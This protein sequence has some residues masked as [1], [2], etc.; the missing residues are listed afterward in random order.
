MIKALANNATNGERS[1]LLGLS[2]ANLAQLQGGKPIAFNLRELGLDDCE[3]VIF[4][5]QD[6]ETMA[7]ALVGDELTEEQSA[8]I[9]RFSGS[10]GGH[11]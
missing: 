6:E 3:V 1:L 4:A 7:R 8:E 5:G 9:R 2:F 11:G 10:G